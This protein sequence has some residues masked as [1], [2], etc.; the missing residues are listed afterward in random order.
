MLD[1]FGLADYADD[2]ARAVAELPAEPVLIGHSMGTV[3]VQRY[4]AK[5]HAAGVALLAPC[6]PP[7]PAD[8]PAAWRSC[9]RISSRSCPRSSPGTPTSTACG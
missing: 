3:V 1:S 2:L 4:L 8:R 7:A 5:A 6:R 9:N